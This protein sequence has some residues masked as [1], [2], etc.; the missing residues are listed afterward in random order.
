MKILKK[1]SLLV[2][3]FFCITFLDV[4]AIVISG[5]FPT[6]LSTISEGALLEYHPTWFHY[7]YNDNYAIICTE[8]NNINIP[9]G[10]TC[11][12][13][14]DWNSAIRAGVAAI[15]ESAN[16]PAGN[17]NNSTDRENYYYLQTTI[18]RFLYNKLGHNINEVNNNYINNSFLTAANTAFDNYS[19]A[20]N[21]TLNRTNI[22]LTES[23]NYYISPTITVSASNLSSYTV[24][25]SGDLE[26]YDKTGNNF[27]VRVAKSKVES[28]SIG[29]FTITVVGKKEYYQARNYNCGTNNQTVTPNITKLYSMDSTTTTTASVSTGS[30]SVTKKD[31][32]G[33]NLAGAVLQLYKG[34][35]LIQEWTST[36]SS[37]VISNLVVD[38]DYKIIEVTAPA[39]YIKSSNIE[40][41]TITKDNTTNVNIT[42]KSIE[43]TIN[44][45][46]TKAE[47]K[48]ISNGTTKFKLYYMN[49]NE[50]ISINISTVNGT[51]K[52]TD[53]STFKLIAGKTYYLKE[54]EAP[55]GY[56][57]NSEVLS[58]VML[59]NDTQKVDFGNFTTKLIINKYIKD[60]TTRLKEANISVCRYNDET[61]LYDICNNYST[62]ENALIINSLPIGKYQIKEE[63]AP[64]GYILDN[65]VYEIEI[66]EEDNEHTI[67]IYNDIIIVPTPEP[68]PKT[69]INIWILIITSLILISGGSLLYFNNKKRLKRP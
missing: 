43:V 69:G 35:N 14:D 53:S 45:V 68:I 65:N 29:P 40:N 33:A 20:F 3:M 11:T 47:G 55:L 26:V 59:A 12:I 8:I 17:A 23:G 28:G 44:K 6:S 13:N 60:T 36:T 30:I 67:D 41:I 5:S 15:I 52:V 49:G 32:N 50:E 51:V 34:N 62:D 16:L 54:L 18:N 9:I 66:T 27:K 42:N 1:L 25:G 61:D 38:D 56:T 58:F 10:R 63:S 7:K 64:D 2:A 24:T 4:K 31:K 39:G 22:I 37:K 48:L 21:V 19:A 46:D 57:I